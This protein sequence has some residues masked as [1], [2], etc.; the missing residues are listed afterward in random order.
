MAVIKDNLPSDL[1]KIEKAGIDEVFLDLSAHVHS[2]LLERFPELTQPPDQDDPSARLPMPSV[3]ALD[4]Q[5]DALVD[6]ED[7][8]AEMDD[9]DWDD[10]ALLI[11]SEIIRRLRADI[12]ER[13]K[14][15]CSA[16]VASNK[17]LSKLGSGYKKPN[18]QTVVRN[19]AV[20]HFLSGFKFTKIRNLGGKLGDQIAQ[21]FGTD[22]VQALVEVPIEQL[23]SK[24]GDDT[25]VWVY[26]TIRGA[27]ASEVNPRTKIKSMLSAKSF[28]PS[29]NTIEQGTK[30]LKIFAADIFS[31]LVEEGVLENKRWPRTIQLHHRQG[32]GQMRSRS[33][34]L[35]QG[36]RLSEEILFDSAQALLSQIA[37]EGHVWPCANLSLTVGGFEDGVEGNMGIGA[38][39]LKDDGVRPT[40]AR[41]GDNVAPLNTPQGAAATGVPS[42]PD[43]KRK[44][45]SDGGIHRFFPRKQ[46][47]ASRSVSRELGTWDVSPIR[48]TGTPYGPSGKPVK[49]PDD[50]PSDRHQE[51][52]C[53]PQIDPLNDDGL[54]VTDY[55]CL[56]CDF[57]VQ[58]MQEYQNHQDWHLAKDL[59]KQEEMG[60]VGSAFASQPSP[61]PPPLRTFSRRAAA[62][63]RQT[64][65][66][67]KEDPGQSKL[68]FG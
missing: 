58:S 40:A 36:K 56:R 57:T 13:L 44:V 61:A 59:Q 35:P 23:K 7:R 42:Q 68:K 55:V 47:L 14:Y 45:E 20:G 27:D 30:W 9:P 67:K 41:S 63:S 34:P 53:E 8:E 32:A 62:S 65:K 12:A 4:W 37:R 66:P 43:K 38:F 33:G 64:G 3:S 6:L 26:N 29:I 52:P 39:L 46:Q 15:A 17:M 16:G 25:G 31:R 49:E 10:V 54:A 48:G 21:A 1:Q 5:A 2:V 51:A 22:A 24:L 50:K 28:R 18:Q 11:G 60:R 19:R